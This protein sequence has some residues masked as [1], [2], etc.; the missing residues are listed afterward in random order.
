MF[1]PWGALWYVLAT[2]IA[3]IILSIFIKKDKIKLA[4]IISI[5]LFAF[6]LLGNSYYFLI[7]GTFFQKLMDIYLKIFMSSRN[8]LFAGF[9]LFTIGYYISLKENIIDRINIKKLFILFMLFILVQIYEV[10]KI[11]FLSNEYDYFIMTIPVVSL[12]LAIC[13]KLKNLEIGFD[14]KI[15][16]NLSTSI[17]FM[18]RPVIYLLF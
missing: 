1:Y 10:S 18:H 16:R 13:I 15:F 2:I 6:C 12:L 14:T 8:G 3:V 7:N 17:Y 11:R 4:L 5:F 9:P